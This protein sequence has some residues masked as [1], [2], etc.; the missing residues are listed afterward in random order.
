MKPGTIVV[1]LPISPKGEP[2]TWV[3]WAPVM[4]EKTP[5]MV[6]NTDYCEG[7]KRNMVRF[8]EGII[9]YNPYSGVELGFPISHVREILPPGEIS[10]EIKEVLEQD[11]LVTL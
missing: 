2:G 3:E 10:E 6:R 7:T 1:C 4:D 5:Y 11:N 8:E 9:G